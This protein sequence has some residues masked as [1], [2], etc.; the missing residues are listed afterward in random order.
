MKKVDMTKEDKEKYEKI[1]ND[2][3]Q[4][5]GLK[6]KGFDKEK[7]EVYFDY[8]NA[9]VTLKSTKDGDLKIINVDNKEEAAK[10]CVLA[11]CQTGQYMLMNIGGSLQ[12]VQYLAGTYG[13]LGQVVTVSPFTTGIAPAVVPGVSAAPTSSGQVANPKSDGKQPSV[14]GDSSKPTGKEKGDHKGPGVEGKPS[15]SGEPGPT[16]TKREVA[17][18]PKGEK[19]D[20]VPSTAT[21]MPT[22][23][24]LSATAMI[25]AV[26]ALFFIRRRKNIIRNNG[27]A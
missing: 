24:A 5:T 11:K 12:M 7:G 18:N 1:T 4:L 2:F 10:A 9:K 8:N 13:T 16:R 19:G 3:T 21:S 23:I 22:A 6:Y 27:R 25:T 15:P 26:A 14:E 17:G 20:T